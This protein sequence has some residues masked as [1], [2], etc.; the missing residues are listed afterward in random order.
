MR[1]HCPECLWVVT[2]PHAGAD[3]EVLCD[4]CGWKW[5]HHRDHPVLRM[6]PHPADY[7]RGPEAHAV[8]LGG[9]TDRLRPVTSSLQYLGSALPGLPSRPQRWSCRR[10]SRA[11]T[12]SRAG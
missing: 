6:R 4:P 9:V 12:A 8:S 5:M 10:Q 2:H 3:D 11:S 7:I 1:F